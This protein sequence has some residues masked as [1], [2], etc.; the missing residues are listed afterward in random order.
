MNMQPHSQSNA[1]S[2]TSRF[3][4]LLMVAGLVDIDA[5]YHQYKVLD[6][7]EILFHAAR[8]DVQ[9]SVIAITEGIPGYAAVKDRP[10]DF[11]E[12][13]AV[14]ALFSLQNTGRVNTRGFY[15]SH[16]DAGSFNIP[17]QNS[18]EDEAFVS[19]LGVA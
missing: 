7:I 8:L 14:A 11:Y 19:P 12:G 18:D 2:F 4:L 9:S 5:S 16:I 6:R 3:L 17:H 15:S 1:T 13:H 10:A